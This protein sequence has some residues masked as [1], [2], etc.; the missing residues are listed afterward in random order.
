MTI[1]PLAE[2]TRQSYGVAENV[3][4]GVVVTEVAPGS[5]AAEAGLRVGDVITEVD[6]KPVDSVGDAVSTRKKARKGALL[7]R[8]TSADGSSHFLAVKTS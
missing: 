5:K 1:A 8:V 2:R 4:A 3:G 6:R 7:L